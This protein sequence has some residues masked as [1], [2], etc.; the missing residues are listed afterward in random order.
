MSSM[1]CLF[2]RMQ[3]NLVLDKDG[4][5]EGRPPLR[6]EIGYAY[7]RSIWQIDQLYKNFGDGPV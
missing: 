6:R 2:F 1:A 3:L 4:S 7:D 5:V